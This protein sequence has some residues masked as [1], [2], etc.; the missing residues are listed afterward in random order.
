MSKRATIF[1]TF[2]IYIYNHISTTSVLPNIVWSTPSESVLYPAP[3][4]PFMQTPFTIYNPTQSPGVS[5]FI[6]YLVDTGGQPLSSSTIDTQLMPFNADL[7][8]S[9]APPS[10]PT[11]VDLPATPDFLHPLAQSS[12]PAELDVDQIVAAIEALP[13][14]TPIS[15][16]P[17]GTCSSYCYPLRSTKHTF[18]L[19]IVVFLSWSIQDTLN[20]RN[21]RE[22]FATI[23][24]IPS[25]S[26]VGDP[27]SFAHAA[28]IAGARY[29][30]QYAAI[31]WAIHRRE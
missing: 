29:Q 2:L 21:T 7:Y 4:S 23:R 17:R 11:P 24:G 10:I 22:E 18:A 25:W 16:Y 12:L 20:S 1:A 5:A 31:L 9:T 8:T 30:M 15:T 3:L 6:Q 27:G 13:I 14:P 26:N 28:S 19:Y